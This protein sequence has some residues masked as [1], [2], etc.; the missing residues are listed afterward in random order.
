MLFR[1]CIDVVHALQVHAAALNGDAGV[2]DRVDV[3]VLGFDSSSDGLSDRASLVLGVRTPPGCDIDGLLDAARGAAPAADLEVLGNEPG[4]RT[5]RT[6]A[7]SRGFVNAI[8]AQGGAPRFKVKTG[9]SDL[10]V[11]V[12]AWGCQALAYGPGDSK[13]DHTPHEHIS[14]AELELAVAVLETA[15]AVP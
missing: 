9:T 10:N 7:L 14:I 5:D 4:I 13:L 6:T 3:R 11:L 12:P 2:F 15:L 1:S 8:R